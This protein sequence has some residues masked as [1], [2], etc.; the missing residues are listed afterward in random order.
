[1]G[2]GCSLE[3]ILQNKCNPYTHEARSH[4][5]HISFMTHEKKFEKYVFCP[6]LFLTG[7]QFPVTFFSSP[8]SPTQLFSPPPFPLPLNFSP[9]QFSL[10]WLSPHRFLHRRGGGEK[11]HLL[12]I[13]KGKKFSLFCSISSRN[14]GFAEQ[15]S[16][17]AEF[18]GAN[19]P[20]SCNVVEFFFRIGE[21]NHGKDFGLQN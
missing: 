14:G 12:R 8:P 20:P 4:T 6:P 11:S 13:R 7:S 16:I 21:K 2:G 1:M 19:S 15:I 5:P 9:P 10:L 17:S 18:R 3:N